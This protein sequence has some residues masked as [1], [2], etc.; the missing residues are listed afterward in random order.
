MVGPR[1]VQVYIVNLCLISRQEGSCIISGLGYNGCSEDGVVRWDGCSNVHLLLF[2]TA[3]TFQVLNESLVTGE[4]CM[5]Y[6]HIRKTKPF[7]AAPFLIFTQITVGKETK[8]CRAITGL[9]FTHFPCHSLLVNVWFTY[10]D[11]IDFVH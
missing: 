10:A 5:N 11:S 8:S 4:R 3:Y 1:F 7:F 6:P 9:F 2:E